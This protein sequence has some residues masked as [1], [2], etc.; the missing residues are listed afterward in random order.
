MRR[1]L[2]VAALGFA[3]VALAP[4]S[5]AF[6]SEY[7]WQVAAL[8]HVDKHTGEV[9]SVYF[10]IGVNELPPQPA[11][12]SAER[13]SCG[14]KK[15]NGD[16]WGEEPEKHLWL[17]DLT[18]NWAA[19]MGNPAAG[20]CIGI[21]LFEWVQHDNG[22]SGPPDPGFMK[23]GL[24]KFFKA[25]NGGKKVWPLYLSDELELAVGGISTRFQAGERLYLVPDW[26]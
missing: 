10:P 1:T 6:A 25:K 15:G 22:V 19:G 26:C 18:Q 9:T 2:I 17:R 5:A 23:F 11:G 14:K 20:N 4:S 24:G 7:F 13:S 12:F 3:L 16:W 21:E 8:G